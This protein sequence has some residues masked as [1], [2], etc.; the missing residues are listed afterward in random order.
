MRLSEIVARNN[1][2]IAGLNKF[3][4]MQ[5]SEKTKSLIIQHIDFE[6]SKLVDPN[7]IHLIK[8]DIIESFG[9]YDINPHNLFTALLF[10]GLYYPESI[11]YN[12]SFKI[13]WGTFSLFNGKLF[14]EER[15]I[16]EVRELRLNKIL[17]D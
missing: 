16:E 4:G 6:L 2:I 9:K 13:E 15:P 3:I 17:K 1:S 11:N 10:N 14:F 5:Y 7:L 12:D 8:Y